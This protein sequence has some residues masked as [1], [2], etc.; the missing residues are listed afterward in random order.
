LRSLSTRTPALAAARLLGLAGVCSA[1]AACHRV[2]DLD[3]PQCSTNDDCADRG[4]EASVRCVGE[5]CL[6]AEGPWACLGRVELPRP[7][8]AQVSFTLPVVDAL[9]VTPLAGVTGRLCPRLDPPC[10]RPLGA[11]Q[12]SDDQGLVSFTAGDNFDGY[13]ELEGRTPDGEPFVRGLYYPQPSLLRRGGRAHYAPMVTQKEL[14][15]IAAG[16]GIT[17]DAASFGYVIVYQLDC[18]GNL[19][20]G[21][22]FEVDKLAPPTTV[23]VG[24]QEKVAETTRFYLVGRVPN[25]DAPAT[26]ADSGGGGFA[27]AVAGQL[28]VSAFVDATGQKIG[29]TGLTVRPGVATYAVMEPSP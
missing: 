23:P 10:D 24:G 19:A 14:A 12:P 13:V 5:R 17:L 29:Q 1:G 7:Q 22:R 18:Q 27:N 25:R 4:F 9:A 11:P 2:L 6:P 3:E 21:V 26:E 15:A 28:V 20:P 8:G 16:N